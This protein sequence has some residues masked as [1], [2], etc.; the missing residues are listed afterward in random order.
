MRL[1]RPRTRVALRTVAEGPDGNWH[2]VR[3][4]QICA[5]L[6]LRV[7][8]ARLTIVREADNDGVEDA[9]DNC[10]RFE[11]AAQTDTVADGFG[12]G[13]EACHRL[14]YEAKR[15]RAEEAQRET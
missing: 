6:D 2:C 8:A 9:L 5:N 12:D 3:V 15:G 7:F 10:P 4:E 11:N 13:C 1:T 14:N